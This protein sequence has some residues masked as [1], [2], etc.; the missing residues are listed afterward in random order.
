EDM[1]VSLYEEISG[2][3]KKMSKPHTNTIVGC[4]C[5]II[6][7]RYMEQLSVTILAEMVN[8]TP[9]YLCVLFK[10][11]TGKTINEYLT[12]ERLNQAKNLLTHSNIHLYD[13]CYRVGYFS[14]SYFSRMFKKYVG[15]TPREYRENIVASA[16]CEEEVD[17]K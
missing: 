3:L 5:K 2:N 6:E 14:P 7:S 9:A 1:L 17:E 13:I 15:V 4:V 16:Y 12:Q 11:A 10:Q 8:L